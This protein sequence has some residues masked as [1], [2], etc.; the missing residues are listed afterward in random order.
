M[1]TPSTP[2]LEAA[3]AISDFPVRYL[4]LAEAARCYAEAGESAKA[5]AAFERLQAEAPQLRV[6]AHIQ[7]RLTELRAVQ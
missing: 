4:A 6:P 7:A 2:D 1:I 3:S 5:L